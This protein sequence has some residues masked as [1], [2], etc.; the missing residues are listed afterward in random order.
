VDGQDCVFILFE[1]DQDNLWIERKTEAQCHVLDNF[2]LGKFGFWHSFECSD[3]Y[4]LVATHVHA[5]TDTI[6]W[7]QWP[8]SSG[9]ST[10]SH[11]QNGLNAL[12]NTTWHSRCWLGFQIL[13]I[14]IQPTVCEMYWTKVQSMQAQYCT[15]LYKTWRNV[16]SLFVNLEVNFNNWNGKYVLPQSFRI[17]VHCSCGWPTTP[18][19]TFSVCS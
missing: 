17:F 15:L 6:S 3:K 13:Q 11:S 7:W 4:K 1:E 10:L 19:L 18:R 14:L 5:F 12:R 2:L 9:W 8:L 16:F